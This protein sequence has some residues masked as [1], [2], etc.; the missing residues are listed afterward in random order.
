MDND[1]STALGKLASGLFILTASH[2]GQ[3]TGMLAS[4]V[5]QAGFEPPAI[6][7]AVR[8]GRYLVDWLR[9][10]AKVAINIL[11]EGNKPL[12]S[13]FARGFEP[14]AAAFDGVATQRSTNGA[15][16]LT[17]AAAYVAGTVSG[18]MSTGDHVIFAITLTEGKNLRDVAPMTHV[19]RDG[20]RY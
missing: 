12:L 8:Q 13:H 1:L 14:D 10:G 4:W 18:E 16:I 15:P 3:S 19:R 11:G 7:V 9:G 17:D 5:M 20:T 2:Q 6:T